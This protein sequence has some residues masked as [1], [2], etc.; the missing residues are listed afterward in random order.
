M[1]SWRRTPKVAL[2]RVWWLSPLPKTS[3]ASQWTVTWE[4]SESTP[5]KLKNRDRLASHKVLG[6]LL[7][8]DRGT[9]YMYRIWIDRHLIRRVNDGFVDGSPRTLDVE[10]IHNAEVKWHRGYF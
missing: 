5:A 7:P 10:D 3:V 6:H 1:P 8:S 4:S 2:I 9:G